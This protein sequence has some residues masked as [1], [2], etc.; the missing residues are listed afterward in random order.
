MDTRMA[1]HLFF[2]SFCSALC[3]FL[4]AAV[5]ERGVSRISILGRCSELGGLGSSEVGIDLSAV[6][7]VQTFALR[8]EAGLIFLLL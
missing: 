6:W 3:P 1:G 7:A 4:C 2:V 5:K 8:K